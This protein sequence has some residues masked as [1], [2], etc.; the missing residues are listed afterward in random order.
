M[1]FVFL[2]EVLVLRVG[3]AVRY[4]VAE[5]TV[6]R[7]IHAGCPELLKRVQQVAPQFHFFGHIHEDGGKQENLGLAEKHGPIVCFRMNTQKNADLL[8]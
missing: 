7:D 6:K 3:G 5:D 1:C 4:R 8:K 2:A